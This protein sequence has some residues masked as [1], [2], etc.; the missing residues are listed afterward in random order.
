MSLPADLREAFVSAV[1]DVCAENRKRTAK[2]EMENIE[3]AK[4]AG[5][6][7][8]K[9]SDADMATLKSQSKGAFEKYAG[10]IN[11]LYPGDKYR[12]KNFLKEVQDFLQ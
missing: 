10:E 7:F 5:V 3:A 1:H 2:W 8:Y 12:P 4:A 11:Q 9:L 6:A